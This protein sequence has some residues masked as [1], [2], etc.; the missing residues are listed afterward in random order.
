MKKIVLTAAAAI[1]TLAGWGQ[2]QSGY[3][4]T[5]RTPQQL[6][7]FLRYD[8]GFPAYVHAHRGGGY[9]GYPENCI[10]TFEYTLTRAPAFMEVDPRM[11]ADGVL[12]LMHDA[13][14]DRTTNA[15]GPLNGYTCA[16]LQASVRLKDRAGN[17]T[18]YKI[19]TFEDALRWA[20]GRT[21]LIVD[22]K[23]A[24]LDRVLEAIRRRKAEAN[25]IIMAY[26]MEDARQIL[27][28]DS[29]LTMQ[30]FAKDAEAFEKLRA[31]GI[32]LD[33]VVAFVSHSYPEDASVFDLLHKANVK[34]IIGSSRNI[35]R[36]ASGREDA[37]MN[38]L[39]RNVDIIEA[40]SAT[41]AA[42]VVTQTWNDNR[43]VDKYLRR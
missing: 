9:I 26:N 25:V 34:A 22:K 21:V 11:T 27:A 41:A 10:E 29:R 1:L 7:K 30:V 19:P 14:L 38:L 23:D 35:D 3:A 12:V 31:A 15:S 39:R 4:F 42:V 2:K 32:P 33:N 16:Q 37:Y 24:P 8:T 40:D 6:Q 13:T 5:F 28:F 36:M 20:R 17:A 18:P 43:V